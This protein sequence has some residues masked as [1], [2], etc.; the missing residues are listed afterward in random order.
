MGIAAVSKLYIQWKITGKASIFTGE[1]YVT[2]IAL[3]KI[4]E[5][6]EENESYTMFLDSASAGVFPVPEEI[7]TTIHHTEA[8]N[9][10]FCWV[11][12]YVGIVRNEK[13]DSAAKQA[14]INENS[15]DKTVTHNNMKRHIGEAARRGQ[16]NKWL[17]LD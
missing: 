8:E 1:L 5:A 12:G 4:L 10:R 9:L 6:C 16:Q 7:K 11:L 17:S 15:L 3:T 13:S 2:R 14:A